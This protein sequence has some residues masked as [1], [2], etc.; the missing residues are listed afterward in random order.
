MLLLLSG[1]YANV[2]RGNNR[3][4]I[5]TVDVGFGTAS[6]ARATR[7]AAKTFIQVSKLHDL[8]DI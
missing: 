8:T 1:M 6:G 3:R 5:G 2:V 7:L 4:P